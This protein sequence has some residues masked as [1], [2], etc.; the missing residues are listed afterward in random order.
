MG[1]RSCGYGRCDGVRLNIIRTAVIHQAFALGGDHGRRAVAAV[2]LLVRCCASTDSSAGV[3]IVRLN[4]KPRSDRLKCML[5]F[6][7]LGGVRRLTHANSTLS[8]S[9]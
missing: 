3:F 6:T 2:A 4:V 9:L 7:P 8:L 5:A 1:A